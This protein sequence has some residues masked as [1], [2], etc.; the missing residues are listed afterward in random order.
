LPGR[1]ERMAIFALMVRR[2]FFGSMLSVLLLDAFSL[3]NARAQTL[4]DTAHSVFRTDSSMLHTSIIPTG[5]LF[6]YDHLL[7]IYEW[8]GR[9]E[10][11][12]PL[13]PAVARL[14]NASIDTVHLEGNS[15][16]LQDNLI[17]STSTI[18]SIYA[19][20]PLDGGSIRPM[21]AFYGSSYATSGLPGFSAATLVPSEADG[22]GVVGLRY[23]PLKSDL[24]FS[25]AAGIAEQAQSGLST[26]AGPIVRG[27]FYAP[28]EL[29]SDNT[30]LSAGAQVDERFFH[31]QD[32]RYSDDRASFA[33]VSSVGG[34]GTVDSNHAYLDAGLGR[35]DFF[36]TSD[37]NASPI[38]Q[39]RTELSLSLRDSLN[40]P[41]SGKALTATVNAALEPSSIT[42]QSSSQDTSFSAIS[43]LLV[44][45]EISILRTL[46]GGRLDFL[47]SNEWSAQGHISY[48][49]RTQNVELLGNELTGIDPSTVSNFSKILNESS[50]EQRITQAGATLQYRPSP[51]ERFQIESDA[52]LLNY[53][54]YDTPN[55]LDDDGHDELLTSAAARYDRFFSDSLHAWLDLRAARTHLVYLLADRS[56]QNNVTQSLTL[57]TH[58]VYTTSTVFVQADGEVFANY[59]LL[60]YLDSVPALQG[61]G[62]YVMRGLTL[63][64]SIRTPLGIQPFGPAYPFTIEEGSMLQI[65]E[66][67]SYDEPT[68]SEVLDT[69]ITELSGS[70][71]LG[72]SGT[73]GQSP[74][75]VRAGVRAFFLLNDGQNTASL[76][77]GP[78]FQELERQIRIGPQVIVSLMRWHG[79][80]P[81]LN[82][83]VWYS[84][85]KDETFDGS[86]TVP[87]AISRMPQ[88]ESQ[89]SAQWTF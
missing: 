36:Y 17:R 68:F 76:A 38:K 52:N 53:D 35:R 10:Y 84:V 28:S 79:I 16:F 18:D 56:A 27:M 70:L 67:G 83:S 22:Y 71:L 21:M 57:S 61:I 77:G 6:S 31:E 60:D 9:F 65:S 8:H 66:R 26:A 82:G 87:S 40:Y 39:E 72:L 37:S 49:E 19:D 14:S 24:D 43:S 11:G 73:G 25:V 64:D 33:A 47:A 62:N 63:S 41:L 48:D 51:R 12:T 30:L 50:Y 75:S 15:R 78:V 13:S 20:E 23:L 45:N 86:S 46:I 58:A 5:A 74:W 29:V 88:I 1:V 59:T 54:T 42:R 44:P 2:A 69:R 4:I 55:P 7:S 80:G 85:I 3:P 89:L 34:P 32:Q 81:M